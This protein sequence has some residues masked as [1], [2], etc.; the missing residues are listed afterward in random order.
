M[1]STVDTDRY[2]LNTNRSFCK[3]KSPEKSKDNNPQN[4]T[5]TCIFIKI[6]QKALFSWVLVRF[7]WLTL[8][9]ESS[10]NNLWSVRIKISLRQKV[11]T[12]E[13]YLTLSTVTVCVATS[14]KCQRAASLCAAIRGEIW[15]CVWPT[16]KF[17]FR[18]T[19]SRSCRR[20]RALESAL[21]SAALLPFSSHL[22]P[23]IWFKFLIVNTRKLVIS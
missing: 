9:D 2:L 13:H 20:G 11:K 19:C 5:L 22:E 14:Q 12:D 1:S 16:T 7:S 18:E 10:D 6:P 17:M 15:W 23:K 3:T 4:V 8:L 21:R